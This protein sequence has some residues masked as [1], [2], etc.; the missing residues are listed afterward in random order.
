L[1]EN[2]HQSS[3]IDTFPQ[4]LIL[5]P[6]IYDKSTPMVSDDIKLSYANLRMPK[7]P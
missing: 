6:N 4:I 2:I 3:V 5:P 1:S 7:I